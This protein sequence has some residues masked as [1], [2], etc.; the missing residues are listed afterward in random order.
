VRTVG[1]DLSA[2]DRGTA[3]AT[4]DWTPTGAAV[5]EIAVGAGDDL[6]VAALAAADKAGLDSPLGWPDPFARFLAAHHAGEPIAP[7]PPGDGAA[8]RRALAWR[9]TDA[10]VRETVG[11]IPLSVAADRIGHAAFRCA[12]I[13]A[14]LADAG[15][16][17]DRCG[18]GV[19]VEVYP[20]AALKVWGLPHKGLKGP[21]GGPGPI[22]DALV[23]A[24]PWL[25]P[26]GCEGLMRANHD[27]ADAVIA[28]LAARA[29]ALGVATRPDPAQRALARAEGWIAVPTAPLAALVSPSRTSR[30]R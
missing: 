5:R 17:V 29:A 9:T 16:A 13:L 2:A 18:D 4:V 14:R 11:L 27:A 6:V 30:R 25:D 22:V 20:A 15:A 12:A 7:P 19:V 8:W 3:V 21:G 1:V 28:A 24:A 23:R 10:V 26:G